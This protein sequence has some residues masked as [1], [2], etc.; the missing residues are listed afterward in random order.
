MKKPICF[1]ALLCATLIAN[2]I[3]SDEAKNAPPAPSK[4]PGPTA[5]LPERESITEGQLR[6]N[7][8][9]IPYKAVAGTYHFKDEG[10]AVKA[11]IFYVAYTRTDIDNRNQR[12]IAFCFNGG[13][14]ASSVWMHMGLLGPKRVGL[15]HGAAA[16][17]PFHYVENEY[18]LLDAVD[19]VFI[20]PIS[21]GY[22][23]TSQGEDAKQFHN[24]EEDVKSVGE[25]IRLYTTRNNRW[26]SPKYLIGASYGTMRAAELSN[27]L[28]DQYNMAIN[29]AILVSSVLNFQTIDPDEGFNE[30]P[31]FLFLPSY[32]AA[33]W[34]HEKLQTPLQG[35]LQGAIQQAKVFAMNEYA[36]A[37]LQG[38]TLPLE[39]R[40]EVVEKLSMYTGLDHQYI[41]KMNLRITP[42]QYMQE[43]LSHEGKVIGRFD[44]R[45][46]GGAINKCSTRLEYD[47]S[48]D[49][50][51]SAFTAAFNEYVH[52]ELKWT[53]D[54]EYRVLANVFPWSYGKDLNRYFSAV[55]KLRE[56]MIRV[57]EFTVFVASGYYDLATPFL[58]AE[59]TFSHLNLGNH[60]ADRLTMK[61]YPGGHMMY[62]DMPSLKALSSD[63]HAYIQSS[64]IITFD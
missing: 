7:D 14:G 59:Y 30:L 8:K 27:H 21:T 23:R 11:H 26:E 28:Y 46:V 2:A 34:A 42:V 4:I 3:C 40:K 55:A 41:E 62:T 64:S 50:I 54:D 22:S 52:T 47:P 35:D 1:A 18:S 13:P 20:D 9:N 53:Q 43:L 49:A 63:L 44:S 32:T 61:Y 58:A 37:L 38:D 12:P 48:M 56:T 5:L 39:K 25:F 10:G 24:V 6:L 33:A 19:L 45:F 60:L 29:G 57:P 15:K 17:P 51:F 31:F 16:V 36:L